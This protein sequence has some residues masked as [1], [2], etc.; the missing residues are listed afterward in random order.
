M[1]TLCDDVLYKIFDHLTPSYEAR[2]KDEE[3][4]KRSLLHAA[5]ACRRFANPALCARWKVVHGADKEILGLLRALEIVV[6]RPSVWGDLPSYAL[7]VR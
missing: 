3:V 4:L 6:S 1:T 2:R 5:M 7:N